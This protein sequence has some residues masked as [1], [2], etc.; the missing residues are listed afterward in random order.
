MTEPDLNRIAAMAHN[1]DLIA[2]V[3]AE[4]PERFWRRHTVTFEQYS[5]A[6]LHEKT[7]E[8]L[9]QLH[10]F[11][12]PPPTIMWIEGPTVIVPEEGGQDG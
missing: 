9:L 12:L 2:K 7:D 5:T 1:D 11:L 4:E 8:R 10:T 6:E 3:Q